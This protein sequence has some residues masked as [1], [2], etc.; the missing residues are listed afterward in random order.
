MNV[1]ADSWGHESDVVLT[2]EDID[3]AKDV[4]VGYK[5]EA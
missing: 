3:Q 5:F 4:T 1:L 2:F